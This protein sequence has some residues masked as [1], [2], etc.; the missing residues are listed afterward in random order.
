VLYVD[1]K[2]DYQTSRTTN[3]NDNTKTQNINFW[4]ACHA[5]SVERCRVFLNSYASFYQTVCIL[6]PVILWLVLLPSSCF[7][8]L[9]SR[10]LENKCLDFVHDVRTTVVKF[11]LV[12]CGM[13]EDTVAKV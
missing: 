13:E 9:K 2:N 11:G 10:P 4:T 5:P 6:M 3:A 1:I 8:N 7:Y 12:G